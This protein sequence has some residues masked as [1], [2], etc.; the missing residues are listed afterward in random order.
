M[1]EINYSL[2]FIIIIVIYIFFAFLFGIYT[3]FRKI[4]VY[5]Q[6]KLYKIAFIVFY[7]A[8]IMPI[9]I[10]Y[11]LY[12]VDKLK[13]LDKPYKKKDNKNIKKIIYKYLNYD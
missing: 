13:I 10:I 8:I 7:N 6:I 9:S 1:Y 11:I 4:R 12:L 2:E 5:P 3:A